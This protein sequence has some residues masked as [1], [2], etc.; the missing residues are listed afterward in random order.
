MGSSFLSYFLYSK[1][2]LKSKKSKGLKITDVPRAL[3]SFFSLL[4]DLIKSVFKDTSSLKSNLR[5]A[6]L[7]LYSFANRFVKS[8]LL[9][10]ISNDMLGSLYFTKNSSGLTPT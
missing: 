2:A 6:P 3:K 7:V 1:F 8:Y 10:P 5:F 4:F 9:S